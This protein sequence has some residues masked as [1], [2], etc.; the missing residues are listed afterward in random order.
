MI[1][2]FAR[3]L[4]QY[5][6]LDREPTIKFL[7][8]LVVG[9]A[10]FLF[11]VISTLVVAFDDIF[12]RF[13]SIE[14]LRIGSIAPQNIIAP[15]STPFVSQILTQQAQQ[16]AHDNVQPIFDP[17]DPNVARQQTQLAEQIIDFVED[18]RRDP[19]ATQE[20]R[21]DDL[22]QITALQLSDDEKQ[23]LLR[24]DDETWQSIQTEI[25]N[26]L[27]RVMRESI[28]PAQLQTIRDQL[29]TQISVRFNPQERDLVV[30]FI[31]DLI[32]PNTFENPDATQEARDVAEAAVT[33]VQRSFERGQIIV[34][35]GERITEIS[36][37]ALQALG[38]L[39]SNDSRVLDITRA[40]LA[41]ILV[42][43]LIG[44]YLTR[45]EPSLIYNSPRMLTLLAT[46]GLLM[47]IATRF[48]GVNGNIYL[49]PT[50]ALALL[51]VA[52]R[53][54]HVAIIS[55]LGLSVL[56]G[57]MANNSLEIATLI[58]VGGII[59][60]LSLRSAER[61]NAFFVAGALIALA[62]VSVV[63]LFSITANTAE[64][65]EI[66][67]P[68][69]F[70]ALSGLLI[71]PATAIALMYIV[72]MLF[73]LTSALKLLD[74]S[75]PSKPLLQRLLREAPGTYQHSLQVANLAEQAASNIGAN[76][77]LTHVAA[78]Y[79]DIGKM[80]NPV[81]FTENQ[82]DIANPH[83]TLNDP[84]R[85]ADII[86]GHVT[87]GDEMAKKY[88]LPH[89]L[90]D[91]IREH[92][93]TTQVYVFYR[94]AVDAANGDESS[95]DISD[96][97]YPGPVP[98][99]KETAILMLADS[100]EA[101]VRSVKPKNRQEINDLVTKIFDDKRKHGQL[102]DSHLT[103][104]ELNQIKES[105]LDILQGMFHPRI[106]YQ[107]AVA[108]TNPAAKPS[109]VV[110]L[111]KPTPELKEEIKRR[112]TDEVNATRPTPAQTPDKPDSSVSKPVLRNQSTQEVSRVNL[113]NVD[114][115]EDEPLAEVPRLPRAERPKDTAEQNGK[116]DTQEQ[117]T[118]EK[119][120]DES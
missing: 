84:Y 44:L 27:P 114:D 53:G 77:Q 24:L 9:G 103:L 75:Q 110:P 35:E 90:R 118:D 73:N 71:V 16:E 86:I 101:A 72:T 11:V 69:L 67:A 40:L 66:T 109:V 26:V 29:P 37:E 98:Q 88:R 102:N 112:A 13:N 46:L 48:L 68:L 14:N 10:A 2:Q 20:Q 82:Q 115:D 79:H 99:S 97:S 107:E 38:L 32:R 62:N 19:Y 54:Q 1:E 100:C 41:S 6:N 4:E 113:S 61:L 120:T 78:L 96:F 36:F 80:I 63:A 49:F 30:S 119:K 81:Y 116:P 85:S 8:Q 34:R 60:A 52:I 83:D 5:F 95:V 42:M 104:N 45:F 58:S 92:H 43:V 105:F 51:F 47:L 7:H 50:A 21:I 15:D 74:L 17:P 94:R 18:V 25:V 87:E 59:G 57:L 91:F 33:N 23:L 39:R 108:K 55:T 56:V 111:P 70:S 12:I 28:R 22:S 89:R 65:L 31:E 117:S 106:N 93:G 76:A 64:L 3:L